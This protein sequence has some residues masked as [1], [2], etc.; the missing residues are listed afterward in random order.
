VV[1]NEIFAIDAEALAE[2]TLFIE[3]NSA[4]LSK[5]KN[6]LKIGIYSGNTLLETTM[7]QF[8]APRNYK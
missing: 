6:N 7:A 3:I 8:L 2:G 5:D 4:A 1:S